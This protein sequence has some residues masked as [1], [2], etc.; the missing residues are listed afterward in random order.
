[1]NVSVTA[2]EVANRL[3]EGPRAVPPILSIRD[4]QRDY[5]QLRPPIIHGLL[6]QGE[7]MNI[8]APPKT[9]K[10]WLT[11]SLAISVATGRRWL[12]SFDTFAGRVLV[13]DNELHLE[14]ISN[15]VP[16]VAASLGV[17][18]RELEQQMFVHSLRGKLQDIFGL[19]DCLKS[20]EPGRFAL[21]ALDAFYRF[22]PRDSDENDNGTMADIYNHIDA[23]ADDLRCS[24]VLIHH[25]TKGSQSSKAITDVGAGAG[26]QARATDT[27]LILR[28]H[29]QK[30]VVVLD[31]AVRSWPPLPQPICL[32][33]EFPAWRPA[34]DLDPSELKPERTPRSSKTADPVPKQTYTPETFAGAFVAS[35]PKVKANIVAAALQ[36][37]LAERLAGTLLA[38]AVDRGVVFK[39]PG[40]SKQPDRFA[41][42][43]PPHDTSVC[44]RARTPH[45]PRRRVNALRGLAKERARGRRKAKDPST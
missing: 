21:I 41:T 36:A 27:H 18:L 39:W 9:G 10:S 3:A 19:G 24:F 28:P 33:W 5:P 4:L 42:E 31:A 40:G 45:T 11:L 32:R 26:A 34:A 23:L 6:R 8:I 35:E 1:M 25:S 2:A 38:A 15:R 43:K 12:A 22:M 30:G 44:A 29:A 13:I 17:D 16:R 37:G 20:L 7:T 14:T